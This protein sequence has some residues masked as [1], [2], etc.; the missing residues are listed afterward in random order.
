MVY[1]TSNKY[2]Q[3]FERAIL[4]NLNIKKNYGG[5][6]QRGKVKRTLLFTL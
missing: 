3:L 2:V 6:A 1:L 4:Y 5:I